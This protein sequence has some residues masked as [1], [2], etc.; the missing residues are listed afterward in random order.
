MCSVY[1][2]WFCGLVSERVW[3]NKIFWKTRIGTGNGI[4]AH[5]QLVF[6]FFFFF[7]QHKI[8]V[9]E[10]VL[11][12]YF[13]ILLVLVLVLLF[14]YTAVFF[15]S[16]FLVLGKYYSNIHRNRMGFTFTFMDR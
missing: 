9:T 1:S 13:Y 16:S 14:T 2:L 7:V 3:N 10:I 12:Y 15:S 6:F 11:H 8:I 5:A 4:Y